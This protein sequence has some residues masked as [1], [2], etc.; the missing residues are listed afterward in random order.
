MKALRTYR[1][2]RLSGHTIPAALRIAARHNLRRMPRILESIM[3]FPGDNKLQLSKQAV[4][5]LLTD[6]LGDRLGAGVRVTGI[7]ERY[8][9]LHV[10][11]TSDPDPDAPVKIGVH[12]DQGPDLVG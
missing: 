3:N 2:L 6:H 12:P 5:Q 8:G 10:D 11:F 4:N 9:E 7:T 1:S